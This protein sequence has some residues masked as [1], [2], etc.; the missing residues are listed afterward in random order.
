MLPRTPAIVK[1][2]GTI[3]SG[4]TVSVKERF[5]ESEPSETV[6]VMVVLPVALGDIIAVQDGHAP[7]K[8]MFAFDT[9][10]ALDDDPENADAHVGELSMSAGVSVTFAPVETVVARSEIAASVGASLTAVMVSVA[11]AEFDTT[12]SVTV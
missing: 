6:I 2:P 12:V 5:A 1:S 9:T 4:F 10:A 8:E 3:P 11:P 7:E